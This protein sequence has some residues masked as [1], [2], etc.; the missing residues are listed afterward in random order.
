MGSSVITP[1]SAGYAGQTFGHLGK[2][3]RGFVRLPE[4]TT[5]EEKYL[6]RRRMGTY[7]GTAGRHMHTHTHTHTHVAAAE[8]ER[9]SERTRKRERERAR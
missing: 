6:G 8:R 7:E 1:R 9:E 5:E 4:A 3:G 2:E